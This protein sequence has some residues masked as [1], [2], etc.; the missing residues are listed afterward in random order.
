MP[1]RDCCPKSD[2][3]FFVWIIVGSIGIECDSSRI[4]AGQSDFL[5]EM[6]C[7]ECGPLLIAPAAVTFLCL[8]VVEDLVLQ[9]SY[10]FPPHD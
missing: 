1:I 10:L 5:P 9:Y 2:A 3:P 8:M 7:S 4:F 6:I